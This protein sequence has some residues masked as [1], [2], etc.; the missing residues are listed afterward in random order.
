MAVPVSTTDGRGQ[1]GGAGRC[2]EGVG[3]GCCGESAGAER[4]R[5]RGGGAG[6]AAGETM[7]RRR[8]GEIRRRG[9]RDGGD[10]W[11]NSGNSGNSGGTA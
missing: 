4:Y 6:K 10:C 11:K 9:I 5:G 1:R 2:M 8:R 7:V 3:V